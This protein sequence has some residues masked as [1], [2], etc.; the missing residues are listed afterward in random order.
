MAAAPAAPAGA[1]QDM[2]VTAKLKESG[3][4]MKP[5]DPPPK[6]AVEAS[7]P[8]SKDGK[9]DPKSAKA[10]EENKVILFLSKYTSS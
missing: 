10:K 9:P 3:E 8:E 7:K 1:K 4:K 2:P 6:P 5:A